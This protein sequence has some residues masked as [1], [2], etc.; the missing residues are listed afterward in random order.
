MKMFQNVQLKK[1]TYLDFILI[2]KSKYD[3][4]Q[5]LKNNEILLHCHS[6]FYI[7]LKFEQE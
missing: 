1:K 3:D 6:S 4:F 7:G 5:S 2:S